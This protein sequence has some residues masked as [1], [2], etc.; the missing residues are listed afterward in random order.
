MQLGV[1]M[2]EDF[3]NNLELPWNPDLAQIQK[4][5]GGIAWASGSFPLLIVF[6]ELFMQWLREDRA[7]TE[8]ADRRAEETDDEEWRRYNEMLAQYGNRS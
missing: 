3:Y 4:E 6:G 5:G 8:E 1:V 7:E 2:G